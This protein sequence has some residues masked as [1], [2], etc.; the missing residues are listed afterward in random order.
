VYR[1]AV[2]SKRRGPILIADDDAAT[3]D[4]LSEFLTEF[5]Y[6]VV[7]ARDGQEAMDVLLG[8]VVPILLVVDIAMPHVA[9]DG[10][11]RYVQADPVLRFIPVVVVTGT[12]EHIGRAAADAIL[13]KPVNLSLLLAHVRRL[14]ALSYTAH[15]PRRD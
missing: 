15:A 3:L 13:A 8:G 11:L 2:R 12:P 4:G 5:G 14:T 1:V 6:R 10:L 9:G 7:P